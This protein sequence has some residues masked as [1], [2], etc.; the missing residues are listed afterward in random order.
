MT[1]ATPAQLDPVGEVQ[2]IDISIRGARIR[3]R[4]ELEGGTR[5]KLRFRPTT[6]SITLTLAGVVVWTEPL[7]PSDPAGE[8]MSG[9]QFNENAAGL[10]SA[11]ERLCEA[12]GA[13]KI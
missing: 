6:Q 12:G 5:V 4:G 7:D 10:Q 13:T 9:I 8:A 3:H 11:I 1:Q 2:L